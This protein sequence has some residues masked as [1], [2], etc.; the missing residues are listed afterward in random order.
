MPTSLRLAAQCATLLIALACG[1]S[2]IVCAGTSTPGIR[3]T[4][5][6][7]D[8][9]DIT[10]TT[11]VVM[12]RLAGSPPVPIDSVQGYLERLGDPQR[13]TDDAPGSY[14]LRIRHEGFVSQE[15]TITLRAHPDY[16]RGSV[17]TQNLTIVL[18][19][20]AGP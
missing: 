14:L 4:V 10:T 11:W 9:V 8:G 3:L 5:R 15:K 7:P 16:C 1:D 17:V 18:V 2:D 13:W 12:I 20:I 19:P 6:T